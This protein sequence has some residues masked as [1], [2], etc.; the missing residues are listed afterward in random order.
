MELERTL[1]ELK[2]IPPILSVIVAPK[3]PSPNPPVDR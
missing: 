3:V 1:I 2:E